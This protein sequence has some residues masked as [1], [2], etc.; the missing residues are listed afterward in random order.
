[1]EKKYLVIIV[2]I[3]VIIASSLAT[4]L[5]L[6]KEEPTTNVTTSSTLQELFDEQYSSSQVTAAATKYTT[7]GFDLPQVELVSPEAGALLVENTTDKP[8]TLRLSTIPSGYSGNLNFGPIEPGRV[9]AI[10]FPTPG[11]YEVSNLADP[12]IKITVKFTLTEEAPRQ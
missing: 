2:I 12:T 9:G 6:H 11:I 3:F 5:I 1:M 10:D 7:T 4:Y 8:L